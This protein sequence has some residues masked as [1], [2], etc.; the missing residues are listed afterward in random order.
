M[1]AIALGD[2][3]LHF[4]DEG[5]REGPVLVFSNSLGTDFRVWDPLLPFLPEGLR[6]VRYDKAGHGLSK[7]AGERSIAANAG[8]L[9]NLLDALKIERAV[10]VGLSVGG[11]I[12]QSLAA[13]HPGRVRA[14]VLCDTA[15]KIGPPRMWDQRMAAVSKDGIGAISEAILERWF[16]LDFRENRKDELEIWRAMLTRTPAAGYLSVAGAIRDTDLSETT[17]Q[18][19]VPTLCVVGTEDGATTPDMVRAL[20]GLIEGARFAEIDGAGHL[21]CVEAPK[22]LGGLIT[23]FLANNDLV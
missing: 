8:D 22:V 3:V 7:H 14:L 2:T 19:T 16:S 11:M 12:A 6:L 9:A 15:H 10:I 20:A 17:K 21:P 5:P 13:R 23:D 4:A 18:I 1:G